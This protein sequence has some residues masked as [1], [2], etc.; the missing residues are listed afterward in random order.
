MEVAILKAKL[1]IYEQKRI[2]DAKKIAG[3][4]NEITELKAKVFAQYDYYEAKVECKREDIAAWVEI[5]RITCAGSTFMLGLLNAE[6]TAE[7]YAWK[8]EQKQAAKK[9]TVVSP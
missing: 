4:D 3:L 9:V 5:N 6:Q 8:K 2:D 7:Y 1:R